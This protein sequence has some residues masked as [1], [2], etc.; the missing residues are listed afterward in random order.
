M[1]YAS[2]VCLDP[3]DES[4]VELPAKA[5]HQS[6]AM[7]LVSQVVGSLI[8]HVSPCVGY[9]GGSIDHVSRTGRGKANVRTVPGLLG[10]SKGRE[11]AQ[12]GHP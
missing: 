3:D 5:Q 10:V 1:T 8:G 6:C 2:Q 7:T 9:D 4:G 12:K 11:P